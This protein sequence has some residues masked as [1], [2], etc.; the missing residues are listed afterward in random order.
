MPLTRSTPVSFSLSWTVLASDTG[1]Q[2]NTA[3]LFSNNCTDCGTQPNNVGLLSDCSDC[4]PDY[5]THSTVTL[6]F[7]V[8]E[9][10]CVVALLASSLSWAFPS[11][12]AFAF[13]RGQR[14]LFQ[15]AG[16]ALCAVA[17]LV[18]AAVWTGIFADHTCLHH[19]EGLYLI[20]LP[21][22]VGL[23]YALLALQYPGSVLRGI[24]AHVSGRS[25][26]RSGGGWGWKI[27]REDGRK[28]YVHV[29]VPSCFW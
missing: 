7:V 6:A 26:K 10:C 19:A 11:A 25:G 2:P 23:C 17:G 20:V 8:I 24:V 14:Y 28:M 15:L 9:L 27:V 13:V 16:G 12:A 1:N 22:V 29:I 4:G 21:A 18:A 5:N 3:G